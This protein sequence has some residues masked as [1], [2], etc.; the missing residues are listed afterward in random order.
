[1]LIDWFTVS[2]QALNFIIL[3][4]L[5]R[6]FLYRPILDA[7][8]AREKRIASELADADAKQ[9][10]AQTEHAQY[11]RK[12]EEFDQGRAAL[13]A[14]AT[15]QADA[16]RRRLLDDA[17][18]QAAALAS[19]RAKTLQSDLVNLSQALR[20]RTQQEVFAIT[21]KV[22]ADL[23]TTSLEE[24]MGAVFTQRLQGMPSKDKS[25]LLQAL[26]A[27][28]GTAQVRSAFALPAAQQAVI[29]KAINEAFAADVHIQF[30]A[31][32]ELVSGIEFTVN[33]HKIA[34]SIADYLTSLESSVAQLLQPSEAPVT[35]S[36]TPKPPVA[37]PVAA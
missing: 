16:E 9:V 27:D 33:G 23:A 18:M 22:L 6:R 37:H 17:L 24:R 7:V 11:Q 34:W 14:Q 35:R 31:V 29:Q 32:P 30:E 4:G 36:S 5:L 3:I 2:A 10:Q 1:M 8:D 19:A 15:Q 28:S 25:V 26:Q 21:R 13:L 20:V 12:N